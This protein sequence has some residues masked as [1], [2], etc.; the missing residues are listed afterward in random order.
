MAGVD[1][2]YIDMQLAYWRKYSHFLDEKELFDAFRY[3][4]GS[5]LNQPRWGLI[6]GEYPSKEALI[7]QMEEILKEVNVRAKSGN[8]RLRQIKLMKEL[9]AEYPKEASE[10]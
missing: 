4:L 10:V 9:M 5:I 8:S 6:N 1:E 2:K 3:T 7:N